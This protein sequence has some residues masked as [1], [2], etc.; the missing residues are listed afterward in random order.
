MCSLMQNQAHP[1]VRWSAFLKL[2]L[3]G[4]DTTTKKPGSIQAI[5]AHSAPALL[6]H[7]LVSFSAATCALT[8]NTDVTLH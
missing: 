3:K 2:D 4:W 7:S 8:Q 1:N 5:S 6:Q